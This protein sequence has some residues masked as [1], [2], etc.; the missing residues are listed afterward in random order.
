MIPNEFKE[1]RIIMKKKGQSIG[2]ITIAILAL[3]AFVA[4]SATAEAKVYRW[5]WYSPYNLAISPTMDKL[6]PLIEK[7][8]N[9]QIKV[10]LYAGG[11]HP[12]RGPDM[13]RALKTGAC[14]MGDVLGAYCVGIDPRLGAADMPFFSNNPEE[15]EALIASV[16]KDAYDKFFNDYDMMKLASYPFPGQAIIANA[17]VRNMDSLKGKK[18][19]VFNKTSADMIATLGGTPVTIPFAEVYTALQRGVVDG[20]VGSTFGQV[21]S[22]NVEVAKFLTRTH[23]YGQGNTWMVMVS[24]PAFSELPADLQE[25]LREAASEYQALAR[26]RQREID[27]LAVKNAVDEYG[28][29]ATTIGPAFRQEIRERMKEGCWVKWAKTFSGGMELL[30]EMEAF[31]ENWVK[32]HK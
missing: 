4:A 14:Q 16:L 10:T 23:A 22:K 13:P 2:A 8:T 30:A 5:K 21:M 24:K 9:G 6:P 20:A 18:I 31:H 17:L 19:R 11:Q 27:A 1:R 26:K 15:E 32:T 12:F 25:K 29:T 3:L 28:C 7:R